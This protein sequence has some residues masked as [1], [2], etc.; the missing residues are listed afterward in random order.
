MEVGGGELR[1]RR[2]RE[3]KTEGERKGTLK[4]RK[5]DGKDRR[6]QGTMKEEKTGSKEREIKEREGDFGG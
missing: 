1:N 4:E 3:V 5:I 2:K 6:R